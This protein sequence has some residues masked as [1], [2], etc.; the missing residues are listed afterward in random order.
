[1]RRLKNK[2]FVVD[3]PYFYAGVSVEN[4]IVVEAAPIISWSK[5]KTLDM[6]KNWVLNKKGKIEEVI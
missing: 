5:G 2:L 4:N 3:L 1:M 6:L